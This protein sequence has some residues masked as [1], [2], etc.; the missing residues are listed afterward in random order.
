MGW[1]DI[2]KE[3][4][5]AAKDAFERVV[6]LEATISAVKDA[7]QRFETR[8]EASM[9]HHDE[10]NRAELRNFDARLR[11]IERHLCRTEAKV[12]GALAE[13]IRLT[14]EQSSTKRRAELLGLPSSGEIAATNGK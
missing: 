2:A 13:A 11:E 14:I 7:V 12:D 8:I 10:T 4:L 6:R 3:A 1:G 5:G 9:Q